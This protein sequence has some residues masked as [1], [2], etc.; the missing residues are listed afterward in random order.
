MVVLKILLY[1]VLAVLAVLFFFLWPVLLLWLR[2]A[3]FGPIR[4]ARR[5]P[6]SEADQYVLACGAH[7]SV[8]N[9]SYL[10]Q[11]RTGL[12]GKY[13]DNVSEVWGITDRPSALGTIEW[14]LLTGHR[15]NYEQIQ[16][17]MA[18]YPQGEWDKQLRQ[19][20][21]LL[22]SHNDLT[23]Y[24]DN[25]L[26][27]LHRLREKELLELDEP[28]SSIAAWDYGRLINV[29][30]WCAELGYITEPEAWAFMR[31]VARQMQQTYP[32]WRAMSLGYL[33]GRD[34][35]GGDDEDSRSVTETNH[36]LLLTKPRSPWL[37]LAWYTPL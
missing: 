28:I 9:L 34:M 33:L 11:F 4:L 13:F 8:M 24:K 32:S 31:Q 6:L 5:T 25:L 37:R 18:T 27:S 35:W 7:L 17:V 14:L 30:R 19:I 20:K 15:S 29:C 36:T 26:I 22:R 16:A 1:L 12:S 2:Y 10:N 23:T 3:L 21:K